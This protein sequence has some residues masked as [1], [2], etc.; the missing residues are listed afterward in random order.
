MVSADGCNLVHHVLQGHK[1]A[2]KR[3]LLQWPEQHNPSKAD[4]SAWEKALLALA[5]NGRLVQPKDMSKVVSH[6]CYFWYMDSHQSLFYKVDGVQWHKFHATNDSSYVIR[7][8]GQTYHN[9]PL[10]ACPLPTVPVYPVNVQHLASDKVRIVAQSPTS[11]VLCGDNGGMIPAGAASTILLSHQY[12]EYFYQDLT[13]SDEQERSIVE[14]IRHHEFLACSDGSYDPVAQVASYGLVGGTSQASLLRTNGPCPGHPSQLLA[15]HLELYSINV[16]VKFFLYISK[17]DIKEG[18]V[19]LYNDCEKA[20]KLLLKPG[21]RFRRF[22]IDHYDIIS[23][24]CHALQELRGLI[25]LQL[26]FWPKG[27]IPAR[28]GRYSTISMMPRTGWQFQL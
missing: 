8:G 18:T 5:P 3:I 1:L 20:H 28:I 17:Y 4:W 27:I 16:A 6:Q 7:N 10:I 19:T 14:A 25:T 26:L 24:T 21:R 12:Y 11:V 13:L 9:D 23:E 22:L 2:D 15:I